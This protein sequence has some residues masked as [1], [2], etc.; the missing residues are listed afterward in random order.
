MG[1]LGK[2]IEDVREFVGQRVGDMR[3]KVE[4]RL[5]DVDRRTVTTAVRSS[6]WIVFAVGVLVGAIAMHFVDER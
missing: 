6:P 2:N 3:M 1:T 5:G 4:N